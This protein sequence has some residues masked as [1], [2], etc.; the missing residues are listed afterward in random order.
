MRIGAMYRR[1]AGE[2]RDRFR[3]AIRPAVLDRDVAVR[4]GSTGTLGRLL[5]LHNKRHLLAWKRL[6][7]LLFA[8][9]NVVLG[10]LLS[11]DA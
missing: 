1:R 4:A 3:L 10:L 8:M 9:V 2:G 6:P 11:H 5:G 7:P